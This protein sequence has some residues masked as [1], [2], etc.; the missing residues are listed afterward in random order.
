MS[1]LDDYLFMIQQG[2]EQ[3]FSAFADNEYNAQ[4]L[5]CIPSDFKSLIPGMQITDAQKICNNRM[6]MIHQA[7][8]FSYGDVENIFHIYAN[9]AS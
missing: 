3:I 6:K 4:H 8:E 1:G 5:H 9:P 2:N 7:I